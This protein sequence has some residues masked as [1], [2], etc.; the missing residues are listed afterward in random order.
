MTTALL[1]LSNAIYKNPTLP[2]FQW[3]GP[4]LYNVE[5]RPPSEDPK[6][7]LSA[8]NVSLDDEKG[9]CRCPLGDLIGLNLLSEVS[10]RSTSRG[11]ADIICSRQFV[12]TRRGLLRPERIIFVSPKIRRLIE[13]EKLKGI[14]IEIAHLA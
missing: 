6:V 1:E 4:Q 14:E 13:S 7:S 9:E 2:R 8:T 3:E 12:G 10:I 11:D 5:N